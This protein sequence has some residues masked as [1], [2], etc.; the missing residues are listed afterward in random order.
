[1]ILKWAQ[2][3]FSLRTGAVECD[4]VWVVLVRG[5]R[6]LSLIFM[7]GVMEYKGE[8]GGVKMWGGLTLNGALAPRRVGFP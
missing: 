1:M 8:G 2:I 6:A 4:K 3:F 5:M 7:W